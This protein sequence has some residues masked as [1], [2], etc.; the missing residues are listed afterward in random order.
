MSIVQPY[1]DSYIT[2]RDLERR[3]KMSGRTLERWRA[4]DYGPPWY[5][6][7]GSIRYRLADIEDFEDRAQRGKLPRMNHRPAKGEST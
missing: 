5:V 3:W 7:G 4:E 6:L 2:Q 1:I